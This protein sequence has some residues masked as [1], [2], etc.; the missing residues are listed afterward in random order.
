VDF[1]RILRNYRDRDERDRLRI[2]QMA[3]YAETRSCRWQYL[4][5]C[6]GQ[7]DKDAL[8]P[9]GH[10]DRCQPPLA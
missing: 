2:Q 6:F 4:L 10:C 8:A 1:E 5:K 3:E 7:E 9:C